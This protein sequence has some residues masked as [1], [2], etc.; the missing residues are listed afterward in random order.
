MR[1]DEERARTAVVAAV[2]PHAATAEFARTRYS[3]IA[4]IAVE[5]PPKRD[6]RLAIWLLRRVLKRNVLLLTG[7]NRR[8]AVAVANQLGIHKVDAF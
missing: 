7:D 2:R 1:A 5:D 4:L 8:T 6:A 3:P